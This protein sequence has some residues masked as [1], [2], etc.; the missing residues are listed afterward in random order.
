ML[1]LAKAAVA[2]RKVSSIVTI[3]FGVSF[4]IRICISIQTTMN[5]NM[6][7]AALGAKGLPISSN[8]PVLIARLTEAMGGVLDVCE[9]KRLA[10]VGLED[11]PNEDEEL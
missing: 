8:K 4:V 3:F 11:D 1:A 6:L 7:K 2:K 10:G 5:K 9:V